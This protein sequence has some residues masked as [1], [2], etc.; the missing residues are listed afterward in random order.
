MAILQ[1]VV[2]EDHK[3]YGIMYKQYFNPISVNMLALV[4]T[5]VRLIPLVARVN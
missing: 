1:D 3:S 2:F 4:F 5:M